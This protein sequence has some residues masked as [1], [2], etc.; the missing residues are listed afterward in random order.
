[1]TDYDA[2][3]KR[4]K[5]L[6]QASWPPPPP[7]PAKLKKPADWPPAPAG[8]K[9]RPPG[10]R[11]VAQSQM[12][13]RPTAYQGIPPAAVARFLLILAAALALALLID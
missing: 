4:L 11:W 2:E 8:N 5:A 12:S 1:M 10:E 3:I 6:E 13:Y 7:D 9:K